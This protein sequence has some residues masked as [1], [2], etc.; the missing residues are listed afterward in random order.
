MVRRSLTMSE[1]NTIK[2]ADTFLNLETFSLKAIEDAGFTFVSFAIDSETSKTTSPKRELVLYKPGTWRTIAKRTTNTIE[3]IRY[4]RMHFNADNGTVSELVMAL[5]QQLP[6][7]SHFIRTLI[8]KCATT[9]RVLVFKSKTIKNVT[10]MLLM[11]C[12]KASY[13]TLN[14]DYMYQ[15]VGDLAEQSCRWIP[16]VRKSGS[17]CKLK[18]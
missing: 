7:A 1:P 13:E 2:I 10:R 6:N 11:Q 5:N 15:A 9:Q 17:H 18:K 4:S 16:S 14:V 8:I 3:R 12:G